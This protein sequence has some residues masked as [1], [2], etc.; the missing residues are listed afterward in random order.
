MVNRPFDQVAKEDI[1]S[2]VVNEV[3]EGRTLEYKEALPTNSDDAKRELLADVSSF[4]NASG[5]DMLF[6]VV[7][8][9]DQA[10]RPTGIPESVVGLAGV[11]TDKE[12]LRLDNMFR[13]GIQPRITGIR[14]RPVDGFS[15][16]P[17][18]LVRIQ[19][20]YTAPHMVTYKGSSRFFSRNSG[21][22]Y[23]LDVGE[24]R[25]AFALSESLP[26]KIKRFRAERIA[27]IVADEA[28]LPLN[29]YPKVVL[30][31][32]PV[33][34]VDPTAS[35]DVTHIAN[36]PHMMRPPFIDSGQQWRHNF[37]GFFSYYWNEEGRACHAYVQL[38]RSGAIEAVDARV[39]NWHSE[40]AVLPTTG[41]E[42]GL[43]ENLD[44]YLQAL[45]ALGV[46][47]PLFV[48]LTLFGVKGYRVSHGQFR[49]SQAP[50]DRDALF[51]PESIV[52]DYPMG[53]DEIL[54]NAFDALWQS[55]GW[56]RCLNYD[57]NGRWVGK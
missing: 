40:N 52:Q 29:P 51:L 49:T 36:A 54:R 43:I 56:P 26:E 16:S 8:K 34:A 5:G 46:E 38:F 6:G 20:S 39:L 17:V 10:G 42:K 37:D 7:E 31:V 47:A 12:V 41:L 57:K 24:I 13:D 9:R 1:E 53:A 22:K 2:L 23:Q 33:S 11:N 44:S 18:L 55:A 4:A 25:S 27:A 45:H 19:K 15:D 3:K 21:G 50:I 48:M 35:V 14:I 30:H 28:P 32:L